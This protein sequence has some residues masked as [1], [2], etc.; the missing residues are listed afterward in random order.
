MVSLK[1]SVALSCSFDI[2][3]N[4]SQMLLLNWSLEGFVGRK[5]EMHTCYR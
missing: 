5:R 1:G 2:Y 3:L 4:H